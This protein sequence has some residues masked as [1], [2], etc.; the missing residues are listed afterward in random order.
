MPAG[1]TAGLMPV[2]PDGQTPGPTTAVTPDGQTRVRAIPVGVTAAS[3]RARMMAD[4]MADR[5]AGR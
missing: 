5:M 1:M 4:R 2:T 3:M